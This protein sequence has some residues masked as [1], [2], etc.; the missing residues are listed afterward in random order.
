M[1]QHARMWQPSANHRIVFP[2]RFVVFFIFLSP[3][4]TSVIF[5]TFPI[6]CLSTLSTHHINLPALHT[7]QQNSLPR[8][9]ERTSSGPIHLS[10]STVVIGHRAILIWGT[11]PWLGVSLRKT[12]YRPS[13]LPPVSCNNTTPLVL[14]NPIAVAAPPMLRFGNDLEEWMLVARTHLRQVPTEQHIAVL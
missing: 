11:Y 4:Q 13:R 10:N 6:Y 9:I 8:L 2:N 12:R 7:K 3:Y 5:S 14:K 1:W